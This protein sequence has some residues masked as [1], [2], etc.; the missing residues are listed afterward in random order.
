MLEWIGLDI[1]GANI[2]L[3]NTRGYARSEVFP[4]WKYPDRLGGEIGK[5]LGQ[6]PGFDALALTMTG[7]LA[8]CYSTREE[9]VC[10]IL[11]QVTSVFPASRTK[12]YSVNGE[13]LSPSAAGRS[14]WTVAASN[15]HALASLAVRWL[16]G[17]SGLLIDIGSTTCDILPLEKNRVITDSRTDSDRLLRGQLVYTGVRRTPMCAVLKTL[18]FQGVECPVMA[19]LFATMDDAYVVI[20]EV[21]E[22][23]CDCDT[24]DGRARTKEFARSRLARMIGEDA[25]T[26]SV[27]ELEQ[28]AHFAIDQQAEMVGQAIRRNLEQLKGKPEVAVFS[29]HADFLIER[30]LQHAKWKPRTIKLTEVLS[31]SLARCAPAYAVATL[32]SESQI[33]NRLE[34]T[35]ERA[36]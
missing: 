29:G 18:P 20:G 19:E 26:L 16:E 25:T 7:E 32:A 13:W 6:V 23:A 21:A 9:G 14:P 12:V 30:A 11:E 22:D 36:V 5:L 2:K 10:R 17:K 4:L 35:S 3:C 8:D 24:A 27:R 28:M 33:A 15:W 34:V 1:G 31:E